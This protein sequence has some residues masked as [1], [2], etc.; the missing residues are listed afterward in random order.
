MNNVQTRLA[1]W[2]K[3]LGISQQPVS[4]REKFVSAAGGTIS[5]LF[6]YLVC[7]S[8][9]A[10]NGAVFLVASMGASAVL[11]FAVPHGP[12]S[13]PWPVAAGHLVSAL[14]GVACARWIPSPMLAAAI[15]VGISI[16]LMHQLR[17]IHPPGGATALF[18]VVGNV[19]ESGFFF[20]L[21]PVALN[22]L[23]ILAVAVGFNW[24]FS[25]RR[26]PL[27]LTGSDTRIK[28]RR[29]YEP[30][31]HDSFVYALSE[32]DTFIDVSE[33]DLLRIYDLAVDRQTETDIGVKEIAPGGCYSNGK[34][35]DEWWVRQI[36]DE[37]AGHDGEGGL[38][39]YKVVAGKG[40]RQS[41]CIPRDEFVRSVKYKVY[42]DEDNWRRADVEN[43]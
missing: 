28:G 29:D 35:G 10:G 13:Q 16:G 42:R 27:S 2:R 40:R 22:V 30:I 4:W 6:L 12:L 43:R 18:A 23:V 19:Q 37:T 31:S 9:I 8:F 36:V 41:G 17:C 39:A 7:N 14:V 15:A 26:Y 32:L 21:A 20:V 34:Y 25:W 1:S 33:Q 38:V 11:L 24:F 3:L 5:I